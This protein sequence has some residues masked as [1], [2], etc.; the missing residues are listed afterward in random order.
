[1]QALIKLAT[2]LIP[3]DINW[4]DALNELRDNVGMSPSGID[5]HFEKTEPIQKPLQDNLRHGGNREAGGEEGRSGIAEFAEHVAVDELYD[6]I[7]DVDELD[8]FYDTHTVIEN[9]KPD[10]NALRY[11]LCAAP[12]KRIQKF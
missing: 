10:V 6:A 7:S 4:H 11:S 2:A 12:T 1:M 3:R 5:V 8:T 9:R